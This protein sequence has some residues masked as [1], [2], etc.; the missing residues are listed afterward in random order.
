MCNVFA[1][2]VLF[3][4]VLA[5]LASSE[6]NGTLGQQLMKTAIEKPRNANTWIWPLFV[7]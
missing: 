5:D 1:L 2:P 3:C 7:S 4:L 6:G